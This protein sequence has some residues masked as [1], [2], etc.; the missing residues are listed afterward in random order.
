MLSLAV[1]LPLASTACSDPPYRQGVVISAEDDKV[2]IDFGADVPMCPAEPFDEEARLQLREVTT[3]D[4]IEAQLAHES[5][6]VV[7][8]RESSGCDGL[9]RTNSDSG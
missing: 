2:C 4:C 6:E 9:G 5:L 8:L 7:D 1:V 3:G